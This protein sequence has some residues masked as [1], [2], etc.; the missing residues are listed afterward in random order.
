MTL[1]IDSSIFQNDCFM[2]RFLSLISLL[3]IN[4]SFFG[5]KY[6][7]VSLLMELNNSSLMKEIVIYN[8]QIIAVPSYRSAVV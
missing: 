5:K 7:A 8:M 6:D 1:I 2:S 3:S 4:H